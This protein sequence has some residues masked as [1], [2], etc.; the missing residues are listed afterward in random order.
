MPNT[1]KTRKTRKTPNARKPNARF[2][3]TAARSLNYRLLGLP[4]E[5]YNAV[6]P[7]LAARFKQ[8]KHGL[9]L[10]W[11]GGKRLTRKQI[12]KKSHKTR[13]TRK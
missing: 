2:S 9:P 11:G 7:T 1:H 10:E 3:I 5:A 13:K 6:K 12:G 8:A 4:P